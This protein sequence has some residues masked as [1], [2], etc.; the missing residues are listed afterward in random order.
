VGFLALLLSCVGTASAWPEAGE[1]AAAREK[2]RQM[3]QDDFERLNRGERTLAEVAERTLLLSDMRPPVLQ[4]VLLD[5]AVRIFETA[6][7]PDRAAEARRLL[8]TV[9][10]P[11]VDFGTNA[12]L[13]LG[14]FGELDFVRCPTGSVEI[15]LENTGKRRARVTLTRPYWIMRY[16]LTRRQSALYPQLN[17]STGLFGGQAYTDYVN[18]TCPMAA[19]LVRYFNEYFR[20][21]L[22]EGWE[23]RLPTLAEWDH[24]FHAGATD[25]S[26]PFY[27]L[28]RSHWG[29]ELDESLYYNM[30]QMGP[31]RVKPHNRWGL[32]DWCRLEKLCDTIDPAR[33]VKGKEDNA[34]HYIVDA[35]PAPAPTDPRWS[36][37]GPQAVALIRM[38]MHAC[39]KA[40]T[41]D[42][43]NDWCPIRLVLAPKLSPSVP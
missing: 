37:T 27:D 30:Y 26:D 15:A 8:E 21:R 39:W 17:P 41:L 16:P 1:R 20:G 6:G 23:L 13:K 43:D 3:L 18:L 29:D 22:P 10:T 38:P 31:Q 4:S 19:G 14:S 35:I 32:G 40:S 5:G 7:L 11:F 28:Y 24:A 36:D 9:R 12:V 2:A 33:I 25:A 34:K 42:Y